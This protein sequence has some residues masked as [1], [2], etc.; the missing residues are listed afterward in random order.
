MK[1]G[2]MDLPSPVGLA[3]GFQGTVLGYLCM[4]GNQPN[5]V[6]ES[7]LSPHSCAVYKYCRCRCRMCGGNGNGTGRAPVPYAFLFLRLGGGR[8]ATPAFVPKFLNVMSW[9]VG[10]GHWGCKHTC[11]WAIL[12]SNQ[13]LSHTI[14]LSMMDW[15]SSNH[16]LFL[17]W[18]VISTWG[19]GLVRVVWV[20]PE[21]KWWV[22]FGC[23]SGH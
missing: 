4:A 23:P 15:P 7:S 16:L 18:L 11:S 12:P 9:S 13:L 19:S 14:K 21:Y 10:W 3:A 20:F 1:S 6:G 22:H 2:P 17:W 5:R 8:V